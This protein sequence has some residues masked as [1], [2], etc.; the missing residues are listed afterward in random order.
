[1]GLVRGLR[2]FAIPIAV[3]LTV[4]LGGIA[5]IVVDAHSKSQQQL[6]RA[7]YARP[8]IAAALFAGLLRGSSDAASVPS[9]LRNATVTQSE[10]RTDAGQGGQ[11]LAVYAADG[12]L[13]ASRQISPR[14]PVASAPQQRL[15]MAQA[16][17]QGPRSPR[18]SVRRPRPASRWP[19][20]TAPATGGA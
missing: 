11:R 4:A 3:M 9:N 5:V 14:A 18:Y 2:G 7:F 6:E 15:V 17:R 16:I 13:L 19:R 12:K 8:R 1:M 10:L 20:D